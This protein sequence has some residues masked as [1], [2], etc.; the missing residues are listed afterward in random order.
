[1]LILYANNTLTYLVSNI[2][3]VSQ[4]FLLS[5]TPST[6]SM[7]VM[8]LYVQNLTAE[9]K[10]N[11]QANNM[12]LLLHKVTSGHAKFSIRFRFKINKSY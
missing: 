7:L 5:I 9:V 6:S 8:C 12:G 10:R 11:K 2:K 3:E 1:M 4:L